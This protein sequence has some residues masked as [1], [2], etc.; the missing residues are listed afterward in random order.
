[1]TDFFCC[2]TPFHTRICARQVV[3]F[4]DLIFWWTWMGSTDFHRMRSDGCCPRLR[5]TNN[6]VFD[7]IWAYYRVRNFGVPEFTALTAWEFAFAS[8][9][10]GSRLQL[11][12]LPKIVWWGWI[13]W[14]H[15]IFALQDPEIE[16][17]FRSRPSSPA[18]KTSRATSTQRSV[19]SMRRLQAGNK[20]VCCPSS[21][22]RSKSI[23]YIWICC[24]ICVQACRFAYIHITLYKSRFKQLKLPVRLF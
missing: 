21:V 16:I 11:C 10:Q 17:T 7:F 3:T 12:W 14:V 15:F 9:H 20:A 5:S 4:E 18:L 2:F 1:M 13:Q 19:S 6:I 23:K 24:W 22:Y 8:G